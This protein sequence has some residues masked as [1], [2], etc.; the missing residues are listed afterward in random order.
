MQGTG[1][2]AVRGAL[3][4]SSE[5]WVLG[6]RWSRTETRR[7]S[8]KGLLTPSLLTFWLFSLVSTWPRLSVSWGS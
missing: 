7:P 6:A 5:T 8:T 1:E 4:L 2:G 3:S